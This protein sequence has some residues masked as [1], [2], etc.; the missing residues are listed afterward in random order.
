MSD[1][2]NPDHYKF[3]GGHEVINISEH[4]T[5][6]A[7]QAVQYLSRACRTDGRVKGDPIEDLK[8]AVWFASRELARLEAL[9]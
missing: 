5:S 8:K 7:G 3:P 4:L 2:I 9:Q 1:A 6:N